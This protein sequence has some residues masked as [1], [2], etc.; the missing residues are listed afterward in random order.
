MSRV[1]LGS[2]ATVELI[3]S[4]RAIGHLPTPSYVADLAQTVGDMWP[5]LAQGA[6]GR[7]EFEVF[8]PPL[9]IGFSLSDTDFEKI[10]SD[11]P[12]V[13][14][15]RRRKAM[16]AVFS[17]LDHDA[18]MPTIADKGRINVRRATPREINAEGLDF[19]NDNVTE[20]EAGHLVLHELKPK[21]RNYVLDPT[22][23]VG[24]RIA[25]NRI[26][27]FAQGDIPVPNLANK[28]VMVV[29]F[30]LLTIDGEPVAVSEN[31]T[32]RTYYLDAKGRA[33][34]DDHAQMFQRTLSRAF[35]GK[36][37]SRALDKADKIKNADLLTRNKPFDANDYPLFFD[38]VIRF[39][40]LGEKSARCKAS[41]P[42]VPAD[43]RMGPSR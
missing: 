43:S 39:E 9:F 7:F 6:H 5:D 11:E 38:D 15:R 42:R 4:M 22:E 1:V 20:I 13:D 2:E 37:V 29:N 26:T 8:S 40:V 30:H 12:L 3:R 14:Q 36:H 16:Q 17:M 21:L 25:F 31:T 18:D 41:L 28:K 35:S 19:W 10:R 33:D 23:Q 24:Y 27:P 34:P 32:A